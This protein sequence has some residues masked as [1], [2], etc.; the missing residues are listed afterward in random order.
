MKFAALCQGNLYELSNDC[1]RFLSSCDASQGDKS[2]QGFHNCKPHLKIPFK[3]QRQISWHK[4]F[5]VMY[6]RADF[7]LRLPYFSFFFCIF[8]VTQM[9]QI[10]FLEIFPALQYRIK[11]T[12]LSEDRNSPMFPLSFSLPH[13]FLLHRKKHTH[14][15]N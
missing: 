10:M 5:P 2:S 12:I 7:N 15:L 3:V 11:A 13:S 14:I 8:S 9:T 6:S 4:P 1:L